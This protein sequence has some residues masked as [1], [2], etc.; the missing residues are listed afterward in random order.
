MNISNKR[1]IIFFIVL[2]IVGAA[3]V[4]LIS[5]L[6]KDDS[7]TPSFEDRI[8]VGGLFILSCI[9]GISLALKPN[10]RRRCFKAFSSNDV[11]ESGKRRVK[12]RDRKG[13]HPD[14]Q[15]FQRHVLRTR[16]KVLCAG[17]TGLAI[18]SLVSI[19]WMSYYIFFP[20][21]SD[22]ESPLNM[23]IAGLVLIAI[24]NLTVYLLT[25]KSSHHMIMNLIMVVGFLLVVIGTLETTG[26]PY[27]G[28][29]AIIFCFLWLDTRIQLSNY[30]HQRICTDCK[31][32]CK[33]Y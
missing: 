23:I 2:S 17:C 6:G 28:I 8:I 1:D 9:Y 11:I 29:V 27:F 13:H 31:E 4:L 25:M 30:H 33:A 16:N 12:R 3:M 20:D 32:E 7:D 18:G 5:W 10:W 19:G 15:N 22:T 14:C 24:C 21:L 26:E